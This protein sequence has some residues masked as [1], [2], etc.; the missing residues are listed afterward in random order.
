MWIRNNIWRWKKKLVKY[1]GIRAQDN[2]IVIESLTAIED[3]VLFSI[4]NYFTKFSERY[5]YIKKIDIIDND[6]SE[7]VDF[8]T[9]D[10]II[11]KLQKIGFSREV[12]KIIKKNK[13]VE[14]GE[15]GEVQFSKEIFN[16]DNESLRVELQDIKLNYSELF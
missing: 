10:K 9:N 4:S 8:G 2:S 12:A 11:I 16:N 3:V 15:K 13:L 6:W 14:V 7:Y 5:K 1:T